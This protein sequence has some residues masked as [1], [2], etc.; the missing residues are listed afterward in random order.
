MKKLNC[1][2]YNYYFLPILLCQ[3]K[4]AFYTGCPTIY[5]LN[6]NA[7]SKIWHYFLFIMIFNIKSV[8]PF[9][10]NEKR[11]DIYY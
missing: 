6:F 9:K 2:S 1:S 11:K 10:F 5:D 3:I 7:G 8:R 4:Y